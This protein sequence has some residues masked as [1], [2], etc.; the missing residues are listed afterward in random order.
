MFKGTA[1]TKV[2]LCAGCEQKIQADEQI[3]RIKSAPD[4]DAKMA[5]VDDF[6]SKVGM[7]G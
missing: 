2:R 1:P 3:A 4:H 7:T 5:A 6:L